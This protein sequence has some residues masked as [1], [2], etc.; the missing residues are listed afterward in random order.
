MHKKREI[1]E[2]EDSQI[3]WSRVQVGKEV[4]VGRSLEIWFPYPKQVQ[5]IEVDWAQTMVIYILLLF[6]SI[7][8]S[9]LER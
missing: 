8:K 6:I 3:S 2:E 4:E 7:L 5:E 1:R 9:S